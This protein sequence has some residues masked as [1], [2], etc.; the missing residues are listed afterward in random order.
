MR[1]NF[2]WTLLTQ[3]EAWLHFKAHLRGDTSSTAGS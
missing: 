2:K 1:K 3:M